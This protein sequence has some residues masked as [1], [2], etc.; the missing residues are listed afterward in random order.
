MLGTLLQTEGNQVVVGLETLVDIYFCVDV[1]LVFFTGY[2]TT[3]GQYIYSPR[4]V[5]VKY[6]RGWFFV[7]LISSVPIDLIL[8]LALPSSDSAATRSNH[9]IRVVRMSRLIKLLRLM[10]VS[11]FGRKVCEGRVRCAAGVV[12]AVTLG[13]AGVLQ[14]SSELNI[15]PAVMAVIKLLSQVLLIGHLLA[16]LYMFVTIVD[17]DAPLP[18]ITSRNWWREDGQDGSDRFKLYAAAFYV[19]TSSN[20]GCTRMVLHRQV[21]WC[22]AVVASLVACIC[23]VR[24]SSSTRSHL[25]GTATLYRRRSGR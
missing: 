25:W 4:R 23:D 11:R 21:T 13:A 8:E 14:V 9:L 24:S 6:L 10:R 1:A 3:A 12:P 22:R 16:C 2:F 20:C 19:R 7:D 5:A 18:K 17:D 15:A